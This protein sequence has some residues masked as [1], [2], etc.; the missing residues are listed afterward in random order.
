MNL[1][2]KIY[3]TKKENHFRNITKTKEIYDA[4]DDLINAD[5]PYNLQLI[6]GDYILYVETYDKNKKVSINDIIL[7]W[8][9]SPLFKKCKIKYFNTLLNTYYKCLDYNCLKLNVFIYQLETQ[10]SKFIRC[11]CYECYRCSNHKNDFK[12]SANI[13]ESKK[14]IVTSIVTL[15]NK[16]KNLYFMANLYINRQLNLYLDKNLSSL[17][18]DF[19]FPEYC[20]IEPLDEVLYKQERLALYVLINDNIL[21]Q[22]QNLVSFY[23]ERELVIYDH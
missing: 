15:F 13:Q 4:H 2:L 23:R 12:Q 10:D 6:L 18:L 9:K 8:V 22:K 1:E 16:N 21:K 14:S 11:N 3:Y 19:I 7:S 20:P 5:I 17:V